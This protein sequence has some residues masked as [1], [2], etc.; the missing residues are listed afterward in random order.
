MEFSVVFLKNLLAAHAIVWAAWLPVFLRFCGESFTMRGIIKSLHDFFSLS[1]AYPKIMSWHTVVLLRIDVALTQWKDG[2]GKTADRAQRPRE[3]L[4]LRDPHADSEDNM[5]AHP[6]RFGFPRIQK[7]ASPSSNA[8][9]KYVKLHGDSVA[10]SPEK[11][12]TDAG[13]WLAVELGSRKQRHQRQVYIECI[14]RLHIKGVIS[15]G[16]RAFC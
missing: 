14:L 1:A 2:I 15:S 10:I 13:D 16:M 11:L 4:P 3:L 12:A 7:T 8:G 5:I 9:E 6:T